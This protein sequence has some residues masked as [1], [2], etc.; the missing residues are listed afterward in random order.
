MVVQYL[1]N[2]GLANI[3]LPSKG[4]GGLYKQNGDQLEQIYHFKGD[5]TDYKLTLQ[6]GKYKVVFR[7]IG[8]QAYIYTIEKSFT[9]Q[10]EKSE[11][12]KIY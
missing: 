9:I 5:K 1:L 10:S 6:P 2:H 3:V 11:L 4:Y 12:I 7:S 8:A